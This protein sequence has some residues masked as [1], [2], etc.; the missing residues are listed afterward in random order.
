MDAAQARSDDTTQVVD[1]IEPLRRYVASRVRDRHDVDD[2]VQ[3]TLARVLSAREPLAADA[4]LAYALVVAR[5]LIVSNARDAERARRHAPRVVDLTEPARPEDALLAAEERQAVQDALADLP[6]AQR[7]P[8]LAHVLDDAP[9][10]T[11]AE[12][13]GASAGSLAAQLSRS[14]A[15]LR[16]DYVLAIRRAQLPTARCRPVLLALSAG[17]TRRQNALRA[18]HH[19]ISCATCGEIS[20]PLLERRSALAGILPWLGLGGMVEFMRRMWRTYPKQAT[21]TAVTTVAV[22]AAGT[23]LAVTGDPARPAPP[24]AATPAV[25]SATPGPAALGPGEIRLVRDGSLLL[26]PPRSLAALDGEA[27]VAREV[28]VAAVVADEGLWIGDGRGRLWVQLRTPAGT[29]SPP[30]VRPGQHLSFRGTMAAHDASFAAAAGVTPRE[31]A[32]L[33]TRQGTHVTVAVEG[34]RISG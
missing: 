4:A 17:D 33:L 31:D 10:A 13:S 25:S 1:L 19:L 18:G 32:E 22:A 14:R 3:E 24:S 8:L 30:H 15:K 23:A 28:P 27:V 29:E 11:L 9:V 7:E 34:L 21:A 26:P 5:H 16:L 2:V 6:P 12:E 20:E